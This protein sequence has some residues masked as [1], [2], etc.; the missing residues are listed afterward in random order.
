MTLKTWWYEF[1]NGRRIQYRQVSH[2]L[3]GELRKQFPPPEPPTYEVDI[4]GEKRQEQNPSDP[5]Y[6]KALQEWDAKQ[7]D[8]FQRLILR[9]GVAHTLTEDELAEVDTLRQDMEALGV[10][11][12]DDVA[13]IFI[14]HLCLT[15]ADEFGDF[16]DHVMGV[17]A[18]SEEAIA[19]TIDEFR[20]HVSQDPTDAA[21]AAAIGG[22]L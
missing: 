21:Q 13:Y 8:L 16:V 19:T 3:A 20:Y 1:Q 12:D 5:A 17:S 10:A 14:Y 6:V 15:T 4:G 7:R 2:H 11:L 9:R 18:P 22:V